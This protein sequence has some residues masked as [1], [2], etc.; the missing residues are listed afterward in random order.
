MSGRASLRWNSTRRNKIRK[1]MTIKEM[2]RRRID[3]QA[4]KMKR[5]HMAVRLSSALEQ[6]SYYSSE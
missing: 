5:A 2:T 6:G 4:K 1:K 3:E